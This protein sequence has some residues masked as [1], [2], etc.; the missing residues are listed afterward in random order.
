MVETVVF[1]FRER[2]KRS[3]GIT[4]PETRSNTLSG[5][6]SKGV[7]TGD[8]SVSFSKDETVFIDSSYLYRPCKV[9]N[10]VGPHL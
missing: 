3:G 5:G 6:R 9:Y 4:F 7:T 8:G 10:K 2:D 1:T